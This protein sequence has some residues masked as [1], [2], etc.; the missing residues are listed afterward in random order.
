M[1]LTNIPMGVE[2]IW[3]NCTSIYIKKILLLKI[4][5]PGHISSRPLGICSDHNMCL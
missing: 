3:N 1:A 5:K 4:K 2:F